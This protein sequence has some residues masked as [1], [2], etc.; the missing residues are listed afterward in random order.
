MQ[1]G[2]VPAWKVPVSTPAIRAPVQRGAGRLFGRR[3]GEYTSA[4][5]TSVAEAETGY[6]L[7]SEVRNDRDIRSTPSPVVTNA[8]RRHDPRTSSAGRA[9]GR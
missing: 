1:L 4:S 2:P 6:D 8:S 3:R 5:A 7:P 9:S